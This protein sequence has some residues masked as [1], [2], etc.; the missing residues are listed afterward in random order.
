MKKMTPKQTH[1]CR[2]PSTF[3][4][5]IKGICALAPFFFASSG[6]MANTDPGCKAAF[7]KIGWE[8][9]RITIGPTAI[10]VGT[11]MSAEAI[12]KAVRDSGGRADN[13]A[14]GM[15]SYQND[16]TITP[17]V[18][19]IDHP[20]G[21][22]VCFREALTINLAKK[23]I[24]VEIAK[25]YSTDLC[26]RTAVYDHEMKHVGVYNS[27]LRLFADRLKK[28][29]E[30]ELDGWVRFASHRMWVPNQPTKVYNPETPNIIYQELLKIE[31]IQRQVDSTE[32]ANRLHT[33]LHYC[34]LVQN[35]ITP[36]ASI[37]PGEA[38]K[39]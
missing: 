7:D 22:G 5:L 34:K 19:V 16:Y 38:M 4:A 9:I 35:A 39:K 30:K 36:S 18:D 20:S 23:P 3:Y 10:K 27:F 26:Q 33:E 14:I 6:A 25:E 1:V 13:G 21:K 8:Q 31:E 12:T 15:T 17:E 11:Q 32:E 37:S 28:S 29:L 24:D 2:V